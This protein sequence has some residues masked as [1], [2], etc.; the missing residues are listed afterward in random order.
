MVERKVPRDIRVYE[1]KLL[2]NLSVRQIICFSI[3]IG[4]SSIFV[5]LIARPL[6][7][8]T[9]IMV[10]GVLLIGIPSLAFGY[11]KP[12]GMY[13]EVFIKDVLLYQMLAPKWRKPRNSIYEKKKVY[14]TLNGKE[15]RELKRMQYTH[16]EYIPY[17]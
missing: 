12:K 13:L 2:G 8:S 11:V 1:T 9:D 17:L 6:G 16:R 5:F 4:V 15:K 7:I 14:Y 10:Y 3:A